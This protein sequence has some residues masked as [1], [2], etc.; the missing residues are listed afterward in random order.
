MRGVVIEEPQAQLPLTVPFSSAERAEKVRSPPTHS[1]PPEAPASD[2]SLQLGR[3]Q[4]GSP[5]P[6]SSSLEEAEDSG[7]QT[8]VRLVHHP[9]YL[10]LDWDSS[11]ATH[12]HPRIMH[13]LND[14]LSRPLRFFVHL[15]EPSFAENLV[16]CGIHR[17]V[18]LTLLV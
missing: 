14:R 7:S 5:P 15:L 11:A 6:R 3:S 12:T 4:G 18:R 1:P 10:P 2:P 16:C 8:H 9:T 13:A 17:W